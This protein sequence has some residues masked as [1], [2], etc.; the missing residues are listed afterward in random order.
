[1]HDKSSSIWISFMNILYF[2]FFLPSKLFLN[3]LSLYWLTKK[4]RNY[5]RFWGKHIMA[6]VYSSCK[7]KVQLKTR[8]CELLT[9]SLNTVNFSGGNVRLISHCMSHPINQTV[10][11]IVSCIRGHY[12]FAVCIHG[13]CLKCCE[14][15]IC[16]ICVIPMLYRNVCS[17]NSVQ[18]LWQQNQKK[19]EDS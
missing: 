3:L 6:V 10:L 2:L 4:R 19:K 17:P 18:L 9:V 12:Q 14:V 1:M 7:L 8:P 16:H 13:M 5:R 11:V 15:T